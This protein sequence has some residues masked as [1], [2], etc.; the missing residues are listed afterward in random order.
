MEKIRYH[1]SHAK[2]LPCCEVLSRSFPRASGLLLDN[3]SQQGTG[4]LWD[5]WHLAHWIGVT[6]HQTKYRIEADRSRAIK[7]DSST[8]YQQPPIISNTC[9]PETVLHLWNYRAIQT[10]RS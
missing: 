1:S 8:C 7:P 9:H 5:E 10:T 4:R 2:S 6:L 3:T